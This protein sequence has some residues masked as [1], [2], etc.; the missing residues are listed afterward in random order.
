MVLRHGRRS[1]DDLLPAHANSCK[2]VVELGDVTGA[3]VP[4]PNVWR[5]TPHA[6]LLGRQAEVRQATASRDCVP[7]VTTAA[8]M[9]SVWRG[10][11]GNSAAARVIVDGELV[12]TWA[13]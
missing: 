13:A 1:A 7:P 8:A 2:E 9:R 3:P 11:I 4:K 5:I 12:P 10:S 6:K